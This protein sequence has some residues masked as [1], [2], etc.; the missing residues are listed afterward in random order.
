[1]PTLT[2]LNTYTTRIGNESRC[3]AHACLGADGN[4]ISH[5][6]ARGIWY[7]IY[8]RL[9]NWRYLSRVPPF[10]TGCSYIHSDIHTF[11][12]TTP[13][14]QV[15]VMFWSIHSTSREGSCRLSGQSYTIEFHVHSIVVWGIVLICRNEEL[16]RRQQNK[17]ERHVAP[18]WDTTSVNY[19]LLRGKLRMCSGPRGSH[20]QHHFHHGTTTEYLPGE[21]GCEVGV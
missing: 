7:A 8:D 19:A 14:H 2:T 10:K 1:M 20:R 6:F 3:L 9:I 21:M 12:P 16:L 18:H 13:R 15:C 11:R 5:A 4:S 17:T